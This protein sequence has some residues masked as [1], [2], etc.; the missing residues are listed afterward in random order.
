[1]KIG[2]VIGNMVSVQ[3]LEAYE[4]R[5]LML[6]QPVNPHGKDEG[7][8]TMAID[9]VSAGVGDLVLYSAA[10]GLASAVF[11]IEKAPINELIMGIID[12]VSVK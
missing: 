4:G 1:M 8:A 10:P 7:R 2:R 11:G 3:R 9:Y 6:V 12:K 5:K